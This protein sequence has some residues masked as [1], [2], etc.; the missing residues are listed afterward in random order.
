[1][2]F[3]WER[4]T[5]ALARGDEG[6]MSWLMWA[7]AVM[8]A[9]AYLLPYIVLGADG[10]WMIWDN[11]DSNF[12]TYQVLLD[13]GAIFAG[14]HVI[15][16]Q[17]LGGV[18]RGTLP[19]ELDA[20]VWLYALLGAEGAYVA[21]HILQTLVAFLG[22]YLLLQRHVFQGRGDKTV[23]AGVGLC[24]AL[25]PF[26]PFGGL[27]VAGMPLALYAFLNI[28]AGD[29]HRFNWII[30][31]GYPFYS[32]LVLSG[33]FLLFSVTCLWVLDLVKGRRASPLFYALALMSL[34][35]VVTHYRLFI[36]FLFT[37][38]FISHRVE[39][40]NV[41]ESAQSLGA[42]LRSAWSI[43]RHGQPHAH[44]LQWPLV[45]IT[46]AIT[47]LLILFSHRGRLSKIFYLVGLFI[48]VTSLFYGLNKWPPI[49]DALAGIKQLLPMQ[50][51][52]FHFL[53]PM[54]WMVLF[55]IAL[56]A[57]IR[58]SPSMRWVALAAVIG[59]TAIAGNYHELLKNRHSPSASEFFAVE[60]FEEVARAIDKPKDTY[61]VASLG[62]HPSI[63]L[64]NGFYT[65]DGYWPNYP[66]EY[67]HQF[68]EVIAAELDK[69]PQ[70]QRYFDHWGSRVYVFSDELK[71]EAGYVSNYHGKEII[72][73]SLAL[74][75]SALRRLGAQYLISA[76]QIDE[77]K[78]PYV[79][80]VGAF[81]SDDSVW[82]L[83]LYEI[84][85]PP[86]DAA[87]HGAG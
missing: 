32:S 6:V 67:K 86:T 70:L 83:F 71:R 47:S 57:L 46:T 62:M 25:L 53:H 28:R 75:P 5:H 48:V 52:R 23:L 63:A 59:Q 18:P 39:F 34:A 13:S 26:W 20:F 44:S 40:G 58:V 73:E 66:L 17:P 4:G 85:D 1:M 14:N 65:I 43:F 42:S 11:L 10:H 16:E 15:V 69:N 37:A 87:S 84:T 31:L 41:N 79:K 68:R 3:D 61:R 51:Q 77:G 12:V 81:D 9:A 30:L 82:D 35:Y 74:S 50:L 27:S 72:V 55:A 78:N 45:F 80:L 60:Q 36:D 56:G 54:L 7:F 64:Y 19:S 22:M 76:V 24:F 49:S 38:D 29:R 21:N 33:F 8:A 2:I